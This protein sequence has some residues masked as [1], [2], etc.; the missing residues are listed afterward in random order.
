MVDEPTTIADATATFCE[1]YKDGEQSIESVLAVDAEYDAWTVDDVSVDA[2]TVGEL[3]SRGIVTAVDGGYRISS[4]TAVRDGVDGSDADGGESAS[5]LPFT[6]TFDLRAAGALAGALAFLFGMRI[7]NYEE[8]MRGDH[9]VS[10][11]ND[12]Y[13]Y[14]YWM[15][16]LLAESDGITDIGIVANLPRAA[17]RRPLTHSVHWFSPNSS[18][19][20]S[21]PPIR[22]PPGSP[23]SRRWRWESSSTGSRSSSPTTCGL[24]SRRLSSSR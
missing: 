23:S 10:P 11:A 12:P 17:E 8:V 20:T 9:V 15:E 14:R 7:L 16:E 1:E 3:V 22:S 4:R 18:V 21:G 19:G 13:H 2:E 24:A 5:G 6:T